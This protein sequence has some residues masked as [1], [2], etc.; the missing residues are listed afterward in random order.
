ME[1]AETILLAVGVA[2]VL[3]RLYV[4]LAERVH[5]RL[6]W[7]HHFRVG[8]GAVH[9]AMLVACGTALVRS[10]GAATV[11]CWL[12]TYGVWGAG[13][14][15]L[16]P[17]ICVR[18]QAGMAARLR[19]V[20]LQLPRA[21]AVEPTESGLA[22]QLTVLN[23][24]CA[25]AESVPLPF[26]EAARTGSVRP[27]WR[28]YAA[29]GGT[30]AALGAVA[31]WV[32]EA[33]DEPGAC[34][35]GP[36]SALA[37]A[38]TVIA[39]VSVAASVWV[40]ARPSVSTGRAARRAGVEPGIGP[41]STLA[42]LLAVCALV[43][44]AGIVVI[45]EW[46]RG[47][48]YVC[49]GALVCDAVLSARRA[50]ATLRL[51]QRATTALAHVAVVGTVST[52]VSA[53]VGTAIGLTT[54]VTL[55]GALEL[56]AAVAVAAYNIAARMQPQ[57]LLTLGARQGIDPTLQL[58]VSSVGLALGACRGVDDGKPG[59]AFPWD[60]PENE[61]PLDGGVS[62]ALSRARAR[63]HADTSTGPAYSA[64]E[65]RVGEGIVG[66]RIGAAGAEDKAGE[67]D[68][69]LDPDAVLGG[70]DIERLR[71]YLVS[72]GAGLA[73]A[74]SPDPAPVRT[75]TRP[76]EDAS[77]RTRT[78]VPVLALHVAP[79]HRDHAA[80]DA[81]AQLVGTPVPLDSVYLDAGL[82][83][84]PSVR[85]CAARG[86]RAAVAVCTC[87]WM[88][89]CLR[90]RRWADTDALILYDPAASRAKSRR[91]VSVRLPHD[92]ELV[93]LSDDEDGDGDGG[94]AYASLPPP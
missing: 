84:L 30:G 3:V 81:A 58:V 42:A 50:R 19:A 87:G 20:L 61:A 6:A 90:G 12:Y 77:A 64:Q 66:V 56:R 80:P 26:W 28:V 13:G 72:V 23:G 44:A 73:G 16:V 68:A 89:A 25:T 63:Y 33:T 83:V 71:A 47:M 22:A 76:L 86:A 94:E 53:V 41:A 38:C 39:A 24:V 59:A 48:A 17:L 69:R 31:H 37:V 7:A 55:P 85:V 40:Y 75:A 74:R 15:A 46:A 54:S 52:S 62:S 82:R 49:V 45:A 1:S 79:L 60:V 67:D 51:D 21:A 88:C 14:A 8:D 43:L 27:L 9:A 2:A 92:L 10:T 32:S 91:R 18:L 78:T 4:A 5:A 29:I 65:L 36:A 57:L 35:V 93:D 11:P 70:L 34:A